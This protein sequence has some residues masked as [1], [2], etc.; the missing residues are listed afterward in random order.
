MAHDRYA[1]RK[2]RWIAGIL[3]AAIA[4]AMGSLLIKQ[5]EDW[6]VTK[7]ADLIGPWLLWPVFLLVVFGVVW[8]AWPGIR[9]VFQ[10]LWPPLRSACLR[11]GWFPVLPC[12]RLFQTAFPSA[13]AIA[14]DVRA[15]GYSR[16]LPR[17]DISKWRDKDVPV[18]CFQYTGTSL[19]SDV[20]HSTSE[21][22][23]PD[24]TN[25][26]A[27]LSADSNRWWI[28]GPYIRLPRKGRYMVTF[29]VR[30]LDEFGEDDSIHFDVCAKLGTRA[31]PV[32]VRREVSLDDLTMRGFT[33]VTL[34]FDYGREAG[35]E[36]RINQPHGSVHRLALDCVSVL[37]IGPRS[38]DLSA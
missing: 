32:Y 6:G 21:A 38:D 16:D 4:G 10:R 13:Q 9:R 12:W 23:D 25:G 31:N 14:A 22:E 35:V 11:L 34:E 19:G 37:R 28:F 20:R 2:G 26:G 8:F 33:P 15:I 30:L 24:A 7:I 27:V 3:S 17:L 29:R 1:E 5:L 36:F 18:T